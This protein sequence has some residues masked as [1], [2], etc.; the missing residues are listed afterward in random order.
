MT[1]FLRSLLEGLEGQEPVVGLFLVAAGLVFMVMGTRIFQVLL[2]I[3]Y[4]WVG[5]MLGSSLPLDPFWRIVTGA[6]AGLGLAIASRFFIRLGVAFLAGGWFA[7]VAMSVATSLVA[8]DEIVMVIGGMAFLA[9]V[10]LAF[11][12]YF[13]IIAAIMSFEGTLLIIGGLIALLSQYSS[14]WLRIRYMMIESPTLLA[15]LLLAGTVTGYYTQ[16]GER[17]KKQVGTSG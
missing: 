11:V 15:F 10:A 8:R 7:F 16:I 1:H 14:T 12:V 2:I 6:V 3:S 4:A 5:F 17:Q 13:E 9:A